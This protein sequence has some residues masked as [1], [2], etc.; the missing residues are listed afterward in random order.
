MKERL[1]SI[2]HVAMDMDGTIY[3]GNELFPETKPF[4]A[5]L[6]KMNISYSFLTNNSSKS[7]RDYLNKLKKMDILIQEEQM[8]SS[9]IH[10]IDYLKKNHPAFSRIFVAGTESLRE[11]F[12]LDGFKL[13]DDNPQVV[14]LGSDLNHDYNRLCK[15][16]Y[17][18][19][20]G[21]L[22]LTTHPDIEIP[23]ETDT[24]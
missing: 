6:E 13:V 10:T 15:A 7:T 21:C 11:Q 8:V 14:V 2:K 22:W 20:K 17:W 19:K 12:I 24:C 4:L 3:R 5:L 1:K 9:V 18:I 16:A 23:I